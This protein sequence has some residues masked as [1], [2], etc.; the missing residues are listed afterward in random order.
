M[1]ESIGEKRGA[2][3]RERSK[4]GEIRHIASAEVQ[5][6]RVVDETAAESRKIVFE[7]RMRA[8]MAAEQMRASASR[9]V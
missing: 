3:P 7:L 6:A 4:R 8:R 2:T 1:I 9:A 5:R